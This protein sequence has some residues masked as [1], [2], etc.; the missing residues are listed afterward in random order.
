MINKHIFFNLY[1]KIEPDSA[2]DERMLTAILNRN[3]E[4]KTKKEGV[5]IM[6]KSFN[7]KRLAPIIACLVLALVLTGVIGN[8]ANWFSTVYTEELD[9]GATLNFYKFDAPSSGSIAYDY[10]VT[11]RYLTQEESL[12]LF[13][14]L[15]D[16]SV[17]ATFNTIDNSLVHVEGKIGETKVILAAPGLAMSDVIIEVDRKVSTINGVSVSAGYFITK[18]NSKGIKNIIYLASFKLGETSVYLEIAGVESESDNLRNTISNVMMQLID[19]RTLDLSHI[20]E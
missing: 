14:D 20:T 7:W 8:N 17:Y 1:N 13:G 9:N 2:A 4:A 18:P 6:N 15:T 11:S 5:N 12:N 16:V 10:D 3:Y 19:N